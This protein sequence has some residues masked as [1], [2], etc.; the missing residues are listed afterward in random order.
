MQQSMSINHFDTHTRI[1]QHRNEI[2]EKKREE[3]EEEEDMIK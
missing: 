3:E 2:N 1:D